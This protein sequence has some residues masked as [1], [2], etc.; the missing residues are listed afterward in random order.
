MGNG[1]I[2]IIIRMEKEEK[3]AKALLET[4]NFIKKEKKQ[5]NKNT[6]SFLFILFNILFG[7]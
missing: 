6:T 1:L 5:N 3:K 2:N 7:D 4:W